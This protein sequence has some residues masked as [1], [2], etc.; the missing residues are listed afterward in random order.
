MS[1]CLFI[2]QIVV[3]FEKLFS[4]F[5]N[6]DYISQIV[7][8]SPKLSL[9]CKIVL[10]Y[11][12]GLTLDFNVYQNVILMYFQLAFPDDAMI[13]SQVTIGLA[14]FDM[15]FDFSEMGLFAYI[16]TL[17][18]G[19]FMVAKSATFVTLEFTVNLVRV[20]GSINVDLLS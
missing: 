8:I 16:E 11:I 13:I 4:F 9:F 15:N 10:I 17:N 19:S 14:G 12:L 3:M 18:F 20:I 6:C 1:K 5:T 7:P 2:F